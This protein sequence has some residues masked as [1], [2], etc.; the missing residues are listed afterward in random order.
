MPD[1]RPCV[2]QVANP[3]GYAKGEQKYECVYYSVLN[4]P[5]RLRHSM[6]AIQLVELTN[7]KAF[8]KHGAARVLCGVQA[9]GKVVDE[10]SFAEDMRGL[11]EGIDVELPLEEGGSRTIWLQV[12]VLGL[13]ADFPAAG[14]L[15]PFY[16]SM[17]DSGFEA[18]GSPCLH[19]AAFA[20]PL[21]PAFPATASLSLSTSVSVTALTIPSITTTPNFTFTPAAF[22][23][24]LITAFPV[25]A[26]PSLPVLISIAVFAILSITITPT[27]ASTPAA[28]AVTLITAFPVTASP[29]L[30]ASISATAFAI[31][32]VIITPNFTFTPAAFAIALNSWV[33]MEASMASPAL[34]EEAESATTLRSAGG[35]QR[36]S[37]PH[38]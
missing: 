15:L 32:P 11:A 34:R 7:A 12:F 30:S 33:V 23:I 36:C 37:A 18:A 3:L 14:A 38:P 31:L 8:K 21:I 10:A 9:D 20:V 19:P 28:F 26:P 27:F 16:D 5:A 17:Y 1:H 2:G 6:N 24:T 29:S 35:R 13:S 25:T 22:A 4:L